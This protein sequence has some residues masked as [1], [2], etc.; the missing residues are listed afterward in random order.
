MPSS[1]ESFST[2][3]S[4]SSRS[5][6]RDRR[7]RHKKKKSSSRQRSRS[8]MHRRV[9]TGDNTR[10][11][12]EKYQAPPVDIGLRSST[13]RAIRKDRY[14]PFHTLVR[15]ESATSKGR[16]KETFLLPCQWTLAFSKYAILRANGD[17][18]LLSD[19]FYYQSLLMDMSVKHTWS[20]AHHYDTL[21]RQARGVRG[22]SKE[23]KNSFYPWTASDPSIFVQA[24]GAAGKQS[25]IVR[26]QQTASKSST[27]RPFL[28]RDQRK[29]V[30][31]P[32]PEERRAPCRSFVYSGYCPKGRQSCTFGHRC[33]QCK[34]YHENSPCKAG[35]GR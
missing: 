24:L 18:K 27:D 20:V 6:D 33:P 26:P 22:R 14:V 31:K 8:P 1:D 11:P 7:R 2:L 30:R 23:Y 25:A 12:A 4:E 29:L 17:A 35:G 19:L 9:E 21:F 16:Q 10:A 34:D 13:M 3:S 5:R 28:G 15:E 32:L